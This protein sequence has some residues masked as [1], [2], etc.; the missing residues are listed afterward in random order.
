MCVHAVQ[1]T[2]EGIDD[3][4]EDEVQECDVNDHEECQVEDISKCECISII[5]VA[6]PQH[7]FSDTATAH[8]TLSIAI[9]CESS[10]IWYACLPY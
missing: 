8:K 3:D 2:C 7:A 4:T 10:S 5:I 9:K 1:V 6:G